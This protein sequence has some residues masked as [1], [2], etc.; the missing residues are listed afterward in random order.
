MKKPIT[1][2]LLGAGLRG[3]FAYGAYA[4]AHPEEMQFVAV[5]EPDDTRR[6]AFGKIHNIPKEN[7]F[8][9]WED[10]MAKDQMADVLL[11]C[12]KDETHY[13]SGLAS[14]EIG[15]D[16]L[17]EKPITNNLLET[18]RLVQQAEKHNKLMM[19][20]H[21]LRYTPFFSTLHDILESGELGDIITLEQRE[22]VS[23]WHMAH[24]FVRGNWRN[25]AETSPM[26][27]QKCCHDLDIIYWNVGMPVEYVQSFGSLVHYKPENAPAG[28]KLR[29]TD[30]C[31]VDCAWDAREQYLHHENSISASRSLTLDP[32]YEARLHALQT[33]PHGRCVYHCDNTVVDNQVVNMQLPGGKTAVLIMHGH[34]I[35]AL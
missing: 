32:S 19:V 26:I 8:K 4:E 29:C 28:A 17:M 7:Q 35:R 12:T 1:A 11:N 3:L 22:N 30:G 23:N 6:E 2:V 16:M 27:L 21:V 18:V 34:S 20:C 31:E 15:Y 25:A 13:A 9:T 33:G 14:L 5:A 24:S 10:V